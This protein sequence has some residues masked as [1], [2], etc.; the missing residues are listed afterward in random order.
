MSWFEKESPLVSG[1]AVRWLEA[2]RLIRPAIELP[3]GLVFVHP[4][5]VDS[6][7]VYS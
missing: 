1:G 2:Q 7:I 6:D 4:L 5:P 3:A